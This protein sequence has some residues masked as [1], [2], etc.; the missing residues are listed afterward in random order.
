MTP[1]VSIL[2]P[3]YNRAHLIEE[4]VH[5]ALVQT[6]EPIEVVVV[7]NAST[8]STWD[9]LQNLAKSDR[10][11]RIFRNDSNIGPV[12]NWK[13]CAEEAKGELS[14]IL[15]SDDTLN[16]DCIAKMA[17]RINDPEVSFVYCSAL[18]G[19]SKQ[20]SV[21]TYYL[22]QTDLISRHQFINLVLQGKAPVSPG[23]VLL[24]TKDL[25][26][27]LHIN[28]PTSTPQPYEK[29]G[30]GPDVMIM[31]LTSENYKWVAYI[32]SALVYFRE[33]DRSF[34]IANKNNQVQVGYRS[35]FSYYLINKIGVGSWISYIADSWLRQ[36]RKKKK[37]VNPRQFL[38]QH[39]G[40]GTF[41]EQIGLL[42]VATY[43]VFYWLT[44]NIN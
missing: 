7:D 28:F 37:W 5:S 1:L 27:N 9:I 13:R 36:I 11:L 42:I 14:K 40:R 16:V 26:N 18:I 8:D 35:I 25:I 21:L 10:R 29:H 22:E 44:H 43:R 15:F 12:R 17:E 30:A 20:D 3:V 24:R 33:H 38:L 31:F 23:A 34:T 19:K 6:Y 2:I 39:E 32:Q 41:K 4:T